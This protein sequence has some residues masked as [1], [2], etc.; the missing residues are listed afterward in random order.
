MSSSLILS[1]TTFI[2]G[3]AVVFYAAFIVYKRD[4]P[5]KAA[6][7]IMW[8]A[9]L[10]NMAGII[11][12]WF[13]SYQMGYGHAPLTNIYESLVFFSFA[14]GAVYL[15]FEIKFKTKAF[16]PVAALIAFII[17]A[18]ASLSP[19]MN[20]QIE[21]LIPALQSN[22]LTAHVMTCFLG[23][24]SFAIAFG[25]SVAYL[26]LAG[27]SENGKTTTPSFIPTPEILDELIYQTVVFGFFFL[28][29][30]I[31]TGAVWANTA[32]GRY[33]GWDPKETWSLITWFV[34][35]TLMHVRMIRN[36]GGKR[37]AWFAIFGFGAVLFTYFGV[38]L[39][40]GLHSYG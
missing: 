21:P 28:S 34:Y 8:I 4:L 18:Y 36:W 39:L 33:W 14:T 38:N 20:Q 26:L 37:I 23:Y 3:L 40:S 10:A 15:G 25:I 30:G 2:Y 11:V 27:S 19:G 1:V 7:T 31:I 35:A 32:W 24:A 29:I 22:W 13:E 6:T 9:V 5:G 12:R 17:L 16:G